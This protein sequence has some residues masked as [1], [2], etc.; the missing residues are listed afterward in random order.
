VTR[1][2]VVDL[3]IV[4]GLSPHLAEERSRLVA[5]GTD[6]KLPSTVH[7]VL[8]LVTGCGTGASGF[9]VHEADEW[10]PT[11]DGD[12]VYAA[13]V[14]DVVVPEGLEDPSRLRWEWL[15]D[16]VVRVRALEFEGASLSLADGARDPLGILADEAFILELVLPP[17]DVIGAVEG[18]FDTGPHDDSEAIPFVHFPGI[19]SDL[20]A[21]DDRVEQGD[22]QVR[23]I[24]HGARDPE[25]MPRLRLVLSFFVGGRVSREV[26]G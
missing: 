23:L 24:T 17:D 26:T 7:A 5:G 4:H 11:G 19:D 13:P 18:S 14:D 2:R 1:S 10:V 16:R 21:L 9:F 15:M 6:M 12:L 3:S 8:I 22:L 20:A 25:E